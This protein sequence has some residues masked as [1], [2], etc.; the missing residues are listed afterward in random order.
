MKIAFVF[1]RLR[2]SPGD[3]I[4]SQAYTWKRILEE[5]GHVVDLISCWDYKDLTTYDIVQIFGFHSSLVEEIEG[6]LAKNKNIVIAPILDPCFPI[7]KYWVKSRKG[8]LFRKD[9]ALYHLYRAKDIVKACLVRS[10][11]EKLYLEKAFGYDEGKCHIVPLSVGIP[12]PSFNPNRENYCL[13][14]SRISAPTKNVKRIIDAS[15][16]YNFKLRIAGLLRDEESKRQFYQWIDGKDNVEYLGYVSDNDKYELC[17]KAKVFALPSIIEGVG[18]SALEA[19]A[20][21][22]DIVIT[23]IGGPKEY[24]HSDEDL[25]IAVNPYSV[26]DIGSAIKRLLDGDTFQPKLMQHLVANNSDQKIG[27]MLE[28]VYLKVV[29]QG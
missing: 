24:Y 26:D 6:V 13:H 9:A 23:N 17:C 11:F 19:A 12:F 8:W 14:I 21:G 10:A 28:A 5:R 2:I 22:C 3:G 27:E 20:C 4:I 1:S 25:A 18:L 7:M 16:K 29:G 15:V